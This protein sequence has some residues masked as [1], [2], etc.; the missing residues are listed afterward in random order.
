M[1]KDQVIAQVVRQVLAAQ[2]QPAPQQRMTLAL[3]RALIARVEQKAAE[4]GAR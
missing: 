4:M 3:A 1:D 2:E